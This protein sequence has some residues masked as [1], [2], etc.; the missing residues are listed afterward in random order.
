MLNFSEWD[1]AYYSVDESFKEDVQNWMSRNFGGKIDKIDG[2]ISDLTDI[3]EDFAKE[4]G[5][6]QKEVFDLKN[7]IDSGDY[8]I[9]E[10]REFREK[11]RSLNDRLESLERLKTQKIRDL[12]IRVVALTK[13]NPRVSKYWNL[14][15][16]EAETGVAE[17]LYNISKG[18]PDRKMEDEL[19]K[20]YLKSYEEFKNR[21]KQVD[22]L[23]HSDE[24][25]EERDQKPEMRGL[26]DVQNLISMSAA[27]FASEIKGYSRTDLRKIQRILIDKKN[28]GLNELRSLRRTKA[29]ESDKVSPK[30]RERVSQ[31]FNPMIYELGEII[32]SMREK[33]SY[34]DKWTI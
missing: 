23:V 16:L 9:E 25:K 20:K 1:R 33:I 32:D 21:E 31:K 19:Y 27:K 10:E 26:P 2:I 18:L 30:E 22:D 14:K 29:K 24:E 15:K 7:K 13:G 6:T 4:W 3:E 17:T 8:S 11:I 28:A 12:N 34:I 5:K